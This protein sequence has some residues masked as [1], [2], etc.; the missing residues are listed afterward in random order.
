MGESAGSMNCIKQWMIERLEG[1]VDGRVVG[2]R[3]PCGTRPRFEPRLRCH[4]FEFD[5]SMFVK[6]RP[7][8]GF[9]RR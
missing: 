6:D 3:E 7:G 1:L 5:A 4:G 9:G 8:S 2:T